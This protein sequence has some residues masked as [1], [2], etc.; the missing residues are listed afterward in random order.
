MAN[1][2]APFGP[3][4]WPREGLIADKHFKEFGASKYAIVIVRR[5]TKPH[6]L[7]PVIRSGLKKGYKV[8]MHK[9]RF[10]VSPHP[11]YPT[12]QKDPHNFGHM[13]PSV[14]YDHGMALGSPS[15]GNPLDNTFQL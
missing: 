8:A 3:S 5:S 2:F 13:L 11:E 1:L 15:F 6:H 4:S 10:T 7:P 14:I 12:P 9:N